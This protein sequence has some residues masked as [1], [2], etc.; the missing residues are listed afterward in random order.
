MISKSEV[1]ELF[2]VLFGRP[3]ESIDEAGLNKIALTTKND[4]ITGE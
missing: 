1:S 4:T 3:K 2:I